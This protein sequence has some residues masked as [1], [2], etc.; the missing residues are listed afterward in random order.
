MPQNSY[1]V[2]TKSPSA[3]VLVFDYQKHPARPREGEPI[4]CSPE[5]RLV[6][7]TM[8]GYGLDWNPVTTGR[9]ASG[10]DD[11]RICVW[12][13]PPGGP[14]HG[15]SVQPL[16][17]LTSHTAVVEVRARLRWWRVPACLWV[18]GS[19]VPTLVPCGA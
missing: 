3:D 7:H 5:L 11:M 4:A 8:E 16:I 19:R 13:V 2:A 14:L 17:T 1:F 9:I 18:G 6:G 12:D 10:G 15:R